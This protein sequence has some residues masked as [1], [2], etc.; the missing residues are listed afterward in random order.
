MLLLGWA[1]HSLSSRDSTDCRSSDARRLP[2]WCWWS[3]LVKR[4]RSVL[5]RFRVTP[6]VVFVVGIVVVVV[7]AAAARRPVDGAASTSSTHP[8]DGAGVGFA[9]EGVMYWF[10]FYV[11]IYIC[12]CGCCCCC[13]QVDVEHTTHKRVG[14]AS[15]WCQPHTLK[16]VHTY[17]RHTYIY[18]ETT[19]AR[20]GFGVFWCVVDL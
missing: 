17:R 4:L 11:Y 18:V 6:A 7:P 9:A 1:T 10:W 8:P 3:S 5:D 16:T 14:R 2:S 20:G 19:A 13:V 12:G 15:R